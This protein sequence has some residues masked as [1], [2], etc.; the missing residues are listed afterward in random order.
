MIFL[1]GFVA[2]FTFWSCGTTPA[3]EQTEVTNPTEVV[4]PTEVPE[5]VEGQTE[6]TNE[7][8]AEEHKKSSAPIYAGFAVLAAAL[9]ALFIAKRKKDKKDE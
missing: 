7:S 1:I 6:S 8:L 4:E 2:A 3:P 5:L 9:T